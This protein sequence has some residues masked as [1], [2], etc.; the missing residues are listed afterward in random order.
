MRVQYHLGR[1]PYIK[2]SW[3]VS[4]AAWLISAMALLGKADCASDLSLGING[5]ISIIDVAI[6]SPIKEAIWPFGWP[7]GR[8]NN[9]LIIKHFFTIAEAFKPAIGRINGRM[10]GRWAIGLGAQL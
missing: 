10:D 7:P 5:V 2:L 8:T 1:M 4:L 6:A 3:P 9:V